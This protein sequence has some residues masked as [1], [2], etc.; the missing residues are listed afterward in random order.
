[1]PQNRLGRHE[2]TTAE[3]IDNRH[4]TLPP[5]LHQRLKIHLFAETGLDEIAL[6]HL[7]DETRL[8]REAI[9]IILHIGNVGAANLLEARARALEDIGDTKTAADLDEFSP[10]DNYR[11]AIGKGVEDQKESRSAVVDDRGRLG[12]GEHGQV[13]FTG[14]AA[15]TALAGSQVEFDVTVASDGLFDLVKKRL[16]QR[17]PPQ[18]C[19]DDNTGGIYNPANLPA[20]GLHAIPGNTTQ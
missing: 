14:C 8:L 7:E 11:L 19:M 4:A 5:E 6:V 12:L 9:F 17:R 2:D 13:S 1:M 3:I 15:T 18:V 10:R 16:R 20:P